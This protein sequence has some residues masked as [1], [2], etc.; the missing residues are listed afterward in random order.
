MDRNYSH[1]IGPLFLNPLATPHCDLAEN[2]RQQ[3][4]GLTAMLLGAIG[5]RGFRPHYSKLRR[6]P[7]ASGDDIRH[8]AL[9]VEASKEFQPRMHTDGHG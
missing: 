1:S 6:R 3:R 5:A 8:D 7:A 9:A 2:Q 4:E